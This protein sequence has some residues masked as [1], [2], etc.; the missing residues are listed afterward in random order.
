M[1][2]VDLRTLIREIPDSSETVSV[3]YVLEYGVDALEVH[4]VLGYAS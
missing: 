4:A 2:G 3:E 1:D